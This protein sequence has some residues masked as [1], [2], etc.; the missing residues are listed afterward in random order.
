MTI[1]LSPVLVANRGEIAV[2][3]IRTLREMGVDSVAVYAEADRDTL[4]CELATSAY[5]LGGK[6][7]AETYLN[8]EF[9]RPPQ[10]RAREQ[11]TPDTVS[12]PRTPISPRASQKLAW[13]GSVLPPRP[14]RPWVT[15]F[16][17]ANWLTRAR[18]Q[19]S[20]VVPWKEAA[21]RMHLSWHSLLATRF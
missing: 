15:R 4:A 16:E 12:F 20:P 6:S 17:P 7:A 14:S 3:V 1:A 2:R 9:S 10:S 8:P 19:R 5:S 11:S 18:S 21:S 13:C